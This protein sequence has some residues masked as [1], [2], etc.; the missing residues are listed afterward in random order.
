M[1]R[2]ATLFC[3]AAYLVSL[4]MEAP[5]MGAMKHLGLGMWY[6]ERQA[7]RERNGPLSQT[8]SAELYAEWLLDNKQDAVGHL[9]NDSAYQRTQ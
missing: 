1:L 5:F 9:F 4:K 3:I 8:R 7:L 6:D 2:V